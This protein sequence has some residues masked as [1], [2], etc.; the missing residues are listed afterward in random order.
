VSPGQLRPRP[1]TQEARKCLQPQAFPGFLLRGAPGGALVPCQ[2][3]IDR[4]VF[5]DRPSRRAPDT[6][7][8]AGTLI[9]PE[10]DKRIPVVRPASTTACVGSRLRPCRP[11]L[12]ERFL[13]ARYTMFSSISV[14]SAQV[15]SHTRGALPHP[16]SH[17]YPCDRLRWSGVPQRNAHQREP[18]A[19]AGRERSGAP[20]RTRTAHLQHLIPYARYETRIS[21]F[22]GAVRTR[23]RGNACADLFRDPQ[24]SLDH[25]PPLRL[26]CARQGRG[27][28]KK[29][30]IRDSRAR[31]GGG[32]RTAWAWVLEQPV[33]TPCVPSPRHRP[34]L[35]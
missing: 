35:G 17:S 6:H 18:E 2:T 30:F 3:L 11:I 15:H 29:R 31:G 10:S 25:G 9:P 5:G 33:G 12:L 21:A 24:A 22:C 13:A 16:A 20:S 19:L 23:H 26:L 8:I 7:H 27:K 1:L 32:R 28:R 34:S 14:S 4:S